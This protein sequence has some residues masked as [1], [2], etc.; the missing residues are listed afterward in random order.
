MKEDRELYK[1][2]PLYRYFTDRLYEADR[3]VREN[4]DKL[5]KLSFEQK[6]LKR[7]RSK[8]IELRRELTSK[9]G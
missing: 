4:K 9:Q 2:N 5:L 3:D 8:L 7:G 1:T 6:A